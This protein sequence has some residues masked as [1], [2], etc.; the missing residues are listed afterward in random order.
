MC[1][2]NW[3]SVI[4]YT[5]SSR[6]SLQEF[7]LWHWHLTVHCLRILAFNHPIKGSTVSFQVAY[8]ISIVIFNIFLFHRYSCV[9]WPH[10][11]EQQM[12]QT[13]KQLEE[14]EERF[15]KLQLSDTA[16]FNDRIDGLSVRF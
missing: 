1:M 10:K 8:I 13:E 14:D 12:E 2:P 11:I 5:P 9:G 7:N 15:H 16:N 4:V 6:N 3:S